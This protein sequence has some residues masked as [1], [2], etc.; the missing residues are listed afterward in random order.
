MPF[1]ARVCVFKTAWV[2]VL[3]TV[4]IAPISAGVR[5]TPVSK[6]AVAELP[7]ADPLPLVA[8]TERPRVYD[9]EHYDIDLRFD[10]DTQSV[11][12]T[13][14]VRLAPLSDGFRVLELDA[15]DLDVASV[16]L[17]NGPDLPFTVDDTREKLA[18]TLDRDYTKGEPLTVT[19][20]Y[21]ATPKRGLYFFKQGDPPKSEPAQFWSQGETNDNHYWFPCWDEPNDKATSDLV[22]TIDQKF[23]GLSNGELVDSRANG[24]GTRTLHWRQSRPNAAYLIMVAGGDFAEIHD[25]WRGRPVTYFVPRDKAQFARATFGRTP[26]ML[27]YF[28]RK[29][30]IDYP[31]PKYSQIVLGHF[32]F[33]GMENTSATTLE[34]TMLLDTPTETADVADN[35]VAHELAHQWWGDLV[36][37]RDWSH[38]WLNEGFA[39]YFDLLWTEHARGTAAFRARIRDTVREHIRSTASRSRPLVYNVYRAPFDLFFDGVLYPKG[40]LVLHMLRYVVGDVAF[41]RGLKL[42]GTRNAYGIVTTG[43]FQSAMEEASGQKLGW[44]FDEWTAKAGYPEF[45]LSSTWDPVTKFVEV[46]VRQVQAVTDLVPVFRMPVDI[47]IATRRGARIERV[48]VDA[49]ENVYRFRCAT[50]PTGITI[51]PHDWLLKVVDE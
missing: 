30:G 21:T 17:A 3:V 36:T 10:I 45:E 19:V 27:E 31:W 38:A 22:M 47:Q 40:A 32:M 29:I 20:R 2:L 9:V 48:M 16:R 41:W 24:D 13:T 34:D 8:H 23:A 25:S 15:G 5:Q 50:A 7:G 37:C 1:V 51:D 42:Y 28:T 44:F 49:K 4:L 12:G 18:V 6:S 26:R 46:R 43:D 35:L 14:S 11:D 33:G 39:T